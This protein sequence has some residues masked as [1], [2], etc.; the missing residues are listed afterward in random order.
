LPVTVRANGMGCDEEGDGVQGPEN[1]TWALSSHHVSRFTG[2][3]GYGTTVRGSWSAHVRGRD[4]WSEWGRGLTHGERGR[5]VWGKWKRGLTHGEDRDRNIECPRLGRVLR[6]CHLCPISRAVGSF[7]RFALDIPPR[8]LDGQ[9]LQV[10]LH[11]F[12]NPERIFL[13]YRRQLEP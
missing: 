8:M 9:R 6:V 2:S 5:D 7:G 11:S 12:Y 1:F 3:G 13:R 4:V 10:L